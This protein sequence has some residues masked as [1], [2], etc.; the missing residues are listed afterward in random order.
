MSGR[1]EPID[2][3]AAHEYFVEGRATFLDARPA[4]EYRRSRDR[5]PGARHVD[6][7]SAAEIDATLGELPRELLLIV[8]C[9]E[10]HEAASARVARRARELGLGDASMLLG[11]YRAWKLANLPI[12]PLAEAEPHAE[13][14]A[15]GRPIEAP[16]GGAMLCEEIMQRRVETVAPED[17]ALIAADKMRK[18]NIGFLPVCERDG[19]VV[20]AITDRDITV[21]L[22]CEDLPAQTHVRALMTNEV[23]ACRP[24]DSLHHAEDL[25]AQ[26]QKSRVVC[27]DDLGRIVGVLSLSDIARGEGDRAVETLPRVTA[28]EARRA[29]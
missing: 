17:S 25:M 24:T 8:Y 16:G 11:G 10:P 15:T 3:E 28:R 4:A 20:G 6:P 5:I 21:R 12:E 29:A 26:K 19:T 27:V 9:N 18:R 13:P 1:P 2:V 7:G 23:V 14:A 22:V